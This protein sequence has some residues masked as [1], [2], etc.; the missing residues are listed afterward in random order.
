MNL[1]IEIWNYIKKRGWQ[2]NT[3]EIAEDDY[4]NETAN[5]P[6]FIQSIKILRQKEIE[7]YQRLERERISKLEPPDWWLENHACS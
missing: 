7:E 4:K 5:L 1:Q 2:C 3:L 6:I